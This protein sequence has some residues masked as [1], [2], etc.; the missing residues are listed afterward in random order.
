MCLGTGVEVIKR[1]SFQI[2]RE[3]V[4]G[5]YKKHELRPSPYDYVAD[6]QAEERVTGEKMPTSPESRF[7]VELLPVGKQPTPAPLLSLDCPR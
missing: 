5:I 1:V 6:M 2:V 3:V 4:R 7:W